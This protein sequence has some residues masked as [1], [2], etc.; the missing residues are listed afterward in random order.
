MGHSMYDDVTSM[1]VCMWC[2]VQSWWWLL[3]NSFF[4]KEKKKREREKR[5][6]ERDASGLSSHD[7]DYCGTQLSLRNT[8]I[9]AEHNYHCVT[10]LLRAAHTPCAVIC[11]WV[12]GWMGGAYLSLSL[13]LSLSL[14]CVCVG[15][16]RICLVRLF[17]CVCM[18]G[19]VDGRGLT[20][21]QKT[22]APE[23][24]N[25]QPPNPTPSPLSAEPQPPK[26]TL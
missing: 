23:T 20:P 7:D 10:Q 2:L 1:Q 22:R 25:P 9:I 21:N 11:M 8:I 18:C 15:G 26:P 13:S 5:E 14:V 4:K 17:A 16:Q 12:G 19:W 24:L 3:C 6:R